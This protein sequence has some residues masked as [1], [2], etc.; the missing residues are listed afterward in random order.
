[1]TSTFLYYAQAVDGTMLVALSAITSD[2]AGLTEETMEK[3]KLLL[4]YAASRPDSILTVSASNMV[5]SV[6]SNAFYLTEPKA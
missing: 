1:M 3:T 2:Q 5:F 4:D 6:H